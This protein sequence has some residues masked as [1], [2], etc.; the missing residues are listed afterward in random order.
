MMSDVPAL[1]GGVGPVGEVRLMPAWETLRILPY[2]KGHASV[3]A[4]MYM[5]NGEPFE[6]CPRHFL[7]RM[8]AEAA[9]CGFHVRAAFENEFSLLKPGKNGEGL[10][11]VDST[12]HSE[13][14]SM[15][16][17]HEVMMDIFDALTQQGLRIEYYYPESASGQ[18]EISI[19]HSDA[20]TAATQQVIFRETVKAVAMKH[21]I[22]ASFMPKIFPNQAGNGT[23]L[24]ISLHKSDGTNITPS[25]SAPNE[26]SPTA[27][28]F[29]AGILQHLPALMAI[30]VPS[31]NS[32]RR[33]QPCTWSGNYRCWGY[34]N[35]ECALRVPL[36][37]SSSNLSPSNFELKASD[38]TGNP[39]LV[40]GSVIA[41]GVDGVRLKL[42][43][44]P[45]IDR[46]PGLLSDDERRKMDI[47]ALP[48][49][50][51]DTIDALS[52]N[53]V[54]L[55]AL[56]PQFSKALLAVRMSEYEAMKDM[57]LEEEVE[58]LLQRY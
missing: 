11:P 48:T 10:E 40:L 36:N 46:D 26:L 7:K 27:L 3:M 30:T 51:K 49:S 9:E 34:V 24:H 44:P 1:G 37:P 17:N 56:R 38:A 57:S 54:L 4:D 15:D 39:Y 32:Y 28:H 8:M 31:T 53:E 47:E 35:R 18:Q 50:L 20:M 29:I 6:L 23:H 22:L 33:L 52:K 13:T 43:P 41:A 21:Q 55:K 42:P 45:P 12:A 25:K 5:L 2:A 58:L 16:T 19:R 14:L